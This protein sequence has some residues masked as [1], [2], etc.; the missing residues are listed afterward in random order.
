MMMKV[1]IEHSQTIGEKFGVIDGIVHCVAFAHAEDLKN[2]FVN[3]SREGFL[4]PMIQV[5][6]L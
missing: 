4:L 3:T 5:H 1:F 2:P 6:T